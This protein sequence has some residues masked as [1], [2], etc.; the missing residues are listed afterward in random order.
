M[1]R[2]QRDQPGELIHIDIKKLGQFYNPGHRVTESRVHGARL[3]AGWDF[4]HGA[5]DDAIQ[6]A[7]VEFLPDE[8]LKSATGFLTRALAW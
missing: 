8:T 1:R 7:F 4:V 2:C 5:V 3:G 6:Q